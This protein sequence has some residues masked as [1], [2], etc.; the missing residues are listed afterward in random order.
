MASEENY[1]G[2]GETP[3][4]LPSKVPLTTLNTCLSCKLR[5][6][7]KIAGPGTVWTAG[8]Q[9]M[10]DEN[11]TASLVINGIQHNL[12]MTGLSFPGAHRYQNKQ[13]PNVGEIFFAFRPVG[14][15]DNSKLSILCVPLEIGYGDAN[16]YFSTLDR[17]ARKDRPTLTSLFSKDAKFLQYRGANI[18][19]G[20]TAANPRPRNFCNPVKVQYNYY[21]SLT[22]ARI[23]RADVD[24]FK[25]KL[26]EGPPTP[27]TEPTG[28]RFV[29]MCTLINGIV[30]ESS[31]P[32]PGS[33]DGGIPTNS[34]KCYKLDPNKDV[35]KDKVYIGNAHKP[36][37]LSL[38][39]E[40][41]RAAADL[42][43]DIPSTSRIQ[44]GDV[45]NVLSTVLGVLIGIVAFSLIIYLLYKHVFINYLNVQTLY[46]N[47][48]SA[49]AISASVI[50]QLPEMPNVRKYICPP[51]Q[52]N[53]PPN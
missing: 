52:K 3:L 22:P 26:K 6:V 23:L 43:A 46:K 1:F 32:L 15:S 12:I 14:E 7:A 40:L 25:S 27:V 44:P 13:E 30:L 49:T 41:D 17:G 37:A 24:R 35:V 33:G 16:A 50:S 36:G 10:I 51:S 47:P 42:D 9:I 8:T 34:L 39:D 28:D 31:T 29:K 38:K 18:F 21:L 20:R 45:E 53:S 4:W 5:L 2:C 19:D 48:I 11:P